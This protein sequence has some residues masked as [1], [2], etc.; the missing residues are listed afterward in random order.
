MKA[1]YGGLIVLC[2]LVI[3]AIFVDSAEAAQRWTVEKN[4]P[5]TF[6]ASRFCPTYHHE[7]P[8]SGYEGSQQL[9]MLSTDTLSVASFFANGNEPRVAMRLPFD[10][11][12]RVVDGICRGTA[13]CLYSPETDTIVSRSTVDAKVFGNVTE[14][15]RPSLGSNALEFNVD[16]PTLVVQGKVGAMALSANGRWLA[17]EVK[18]KGV[19]IINLEDLTRKQIV[20]L[21]VQYGFGRD[22]ANELAVTNDGQHVAIMGENAGYLIV[23]NTSECLLHCEI[24]SG[25]TTELIS[26][27]NFASHPEFDASGKRL[28]FYVA[29]RG[30]GSRRIVVGEPGHR[31]DVLEYLALGDS[32]SSGEGETDDRQYR[33]G[34]NE[35]F[36]KC[37]VSTRSYPFL[38]ARQ[39]EIP[40]KLVESVACAG[41]K[42][43]DI[44]G[45]SV[46]YLG[47]GNRLR[48]PG[49]NVSEHENSRLKTEALDTFRPGRTYQ[50]DFIDR[51]QPVFITL[52]IGGNDAGFMAKLKTCAMPDLC[53]WARDPQYRYASGIEIQNL[54]GRLRDLYAQLSSK[55]PRSL[56][57]ALG[58]PQIINPEG[59]CDPVTTTLLTYAERVFMREGIRYI[60]QV[61]KSA[62]ES[63]GITYIDIE[64]SFGGS[65]LCSGSLFG[66]VNG[67][68][69]GDDAAVNKSLPLLKLIGNESFHPTPLGH[70]LIAAM[71]QRD[72]GD[73]RIH[74]E[75]QSCVNSTGPPP[76]SAYWGERLASH[77]DTHAF[78]FLETNKVFSDHPILKLHLR[79]GSLEPGSKLEIELH[80]D[81]HKLGEITVA[82]D[83]SATGELSVPRD[84]IEGYHTLHLYGVSR[85][86]QPVD[87]Y[88]VIPYEHPIIIQESGNAFTGESI[89][90]GSVELREVLGAVAYDGDIVEI[91][92]K[93][94]DD[95]SRW[96]TAVLVGV[97]AIILGG[98]VAMI[99]LL[100]RRSVSNSSQDPGG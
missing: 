65:L 87:L 94:Q 51:Y 78:D 97:I 28:S 22:P 95:A 26:S 63:S 84:M 92:H 2:A 72:Y 13:G 17:I 93:K 74:H 100:K 86:H 89:S 55:S 36:E 47:Q 10:N 6:V 96:N 70:S 41:A 79:A 46:G 48:P 90:P 88:E 37:H 73:L 5:A 1:V 25:S 64:T 52:G 62:A 68:R 49:I 57:Y 85:T 19:D 21:G 15:V 81:P 91:Q 56:V 8:V 14:R 61:I 58:Y 66:A 82:D 54:F 11:Q 40:A 33:L 67:L 12:F 99:I 7:R 29:S 32:F 77:R 50:A 24:V 20:H 98:I 16:N 83:G 34:T 60:N 43:V 59:I 80:S 4:Q 39:M 31:V 76:L 75:C 44:I 42:M 18:D 69:F 23:R 30:Q 9:C 35:N 27:F 45:K 3:S 38:L 71:I 53:E